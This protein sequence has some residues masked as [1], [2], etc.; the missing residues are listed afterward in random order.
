MNC[1]IRELPKKEIIKL[2]QLWEKLNQVHLQDSIYFKEHYKEFTFEKRFADFEKIDDKNI[3]I[4][5]IKDS[6]IIVGYCIATKKETAGE[7]DS[8]YIDEEYRKEGYG[9]KLIDES[10]HWLK[11]KCQK[12]MVAVANGQENVFDFYKQCGFYPRLTYLQL[13]E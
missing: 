10:I 13:K 6:E 7:I 5:I 3:K 11:K 1:I 4:K 12:I 9:K 8:I 2:K